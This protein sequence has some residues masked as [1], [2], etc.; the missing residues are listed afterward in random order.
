M[1]FMVLRIRHC[2]DAFGILL[3]ACRNFTLLNCGVVNFMLVEA[4]F[5]GDGVLFHQVKFGEVVGEYV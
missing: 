1:F 5:V 4:G 3:L 2:W